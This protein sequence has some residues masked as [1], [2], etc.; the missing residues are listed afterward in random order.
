M[1]AF[2]HYRNNIPVIPILEMPTWL[3][4]G[5]RLLTHCVNIDMERK[6]LD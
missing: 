4:E 1:N 2:G 3:E 6:R 5:F